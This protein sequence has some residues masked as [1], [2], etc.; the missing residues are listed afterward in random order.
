MSCVHHVR[1]HAEAVQCMQVV[2]ACVLNGA[3]LVQ[4]GQVCVLSEDL[5]VRPSVRAL[6]GWTCV[7]PCVCVPNLLVR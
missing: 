7:D 2:Y 1:A 3:Y 5:I 4:C 6:R